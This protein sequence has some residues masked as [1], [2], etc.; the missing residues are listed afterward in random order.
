M[1]RYAVPLVLLTCLVLPS[2]ARAGTYDVYACETPAGK[3]TNNS[4]AIQVPGDDFSSASCSAADARPQIVIQS[5]ANKQYAPGR[6]ATMTFAA[7]AGATIADFRIQRHLVQFNPVNNAPAGSQYLYSLVQ[8]GGTPLEGGGVY[9]QAVAA[10]LGSHGAWNVESYNRD[11]VV[12][13]SSYS[14][15]AGY[16]GDATFVRFTLGCHTQPCAL[17]TNDVGDVGGIVAEI[18]GATVT[19]NDPTA[20]KID[21]VFPTGLN[22]G[23]TLGGDEPLTFDA[24]DNSGIKRAE[25]VD[26]TTPATEPMVVGTKDFACDYSF[27]KPCPQATGA[28]VAASA[29]PGGT[30]T[31][32]L[33]LTDAGGNTSD[34]EPFV[35]DNGGP[36][37]GT[38]AS[39]GARLSVTFARNKRSQINVLYGKRATIRGRLLDPAGTPIAGATIGVLDRQLRTGTRYALRTTTTTDADGRFQVLPGPGTA[40]AIRF[41]YRVRPFLPAPSAIDTVSLR[42]AAGSTLSI[43]PK[44]VRPGGSIRISGRLKGL[45]LPR[46]G[47]VV[48]L[49]AYE[50]GKWRTFETVRARKKARF[51]TRYRFTRATSGA[52]FLIRA[53][54]RRDDSYP[55]YLGYSPRVRVRV[56]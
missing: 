12:T 33:R 6:A 14:E 52:S 19:V 3:F 51:S 37:N 22:G 23:G 50:A 2:V 24:D 34:S 17:M 43:S 31:L 41:E 49:Q 55:Y 15:A 16:R 26:V 5:Y 48:D 45:P 18:F 56:R 29:L 25:L 53:R 47:K 8:L 54:I 11:G 40:R 35:V 4:W 28:Q 7:P 30:R 1:S 44:R 46:S 39:P 32:K 21:R 13:V 10:R 27:A 36:L 20:P 38:P 9:D 42:V